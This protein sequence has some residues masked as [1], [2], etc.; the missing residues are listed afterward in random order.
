MVGERRHGRGT[1]APHLVVKLG[2]Q[3]AL[4]LRLV[5]LLLELVLVLLRGDSSDHLER[6]PRGRAS[7]SGCSVVVCTRE[8]LA[9]DGVRS[10]TAHHPL[11]AV[12][13][14]QPL[15]P[16]ST[17]RPPAPGLQ[18]QRAAPRSVRPAR[19]PRQLAP[20]A[21]RDREQRQPLLE[22]MARQH[23][24]VRTVV[25]GAVLVHRFVLQ[26]EALQRYPRRDGFA[27]EPPIHRPGQLVA[28]LAQNDAVL[29]AENLRVWGGIGKWVRLIIARRY[30]R[31]IGRVVGVGVGDE[32]EG[33]AFIFW[34]AKRALLNPEDFIGFSAPTNARENDVGGA[35]AD[36][37]S[38][39]RSDKHHTT[40][41]GRV[42]EPPDS[43]CA[44]GRG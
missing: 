17:L 36:A 23:C 44:P 35:G 11:P 6:V 21:P 1:G 33:R 42:S 41:N 2:H 10:H 38:P 40:T 34:T 4:L 7:N 5:L 27:L 30:S 19:Q 18:T 13:P 20:A 16:A 28:R 14:R 8:S 12:L 9:P 37:P 22:R 24:R 39:S 15:H 31:G 43:P 3:T 29:S 32:R 26:A 25:G